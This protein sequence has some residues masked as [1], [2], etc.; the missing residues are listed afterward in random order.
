MRVTRT[1]MRGNCLRTWPNLTLPHLVLHHAAAT[2]TLPL[3]TEPLPSFLTFAITRTP[4]LPDGKRLFLRLP[5]PRAHLAR[6]R[7]TSPL[8]PAQP[9]PGHLAA[10]ALL[11]RNLALTNPN[12][13]TFLRSTERKHLPLR[14][15]TKPNRPTLPQSMERKPL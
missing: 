9:A 5:R 11:R 10:R 3:G 4:L 7:H 6:P 12:R 2:R 8:R 14:V 15:R 13:P 1:C